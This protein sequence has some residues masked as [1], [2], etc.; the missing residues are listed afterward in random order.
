L[1]IGRWQAACEDP[2]VH[3]LDNP[4][5]HALTGPQQKVADLRS[6]AARYD[7]E[8]AAFAA[9]PDVPTPETWDD[10]RD[11]VGEGGVAVLFVKPPNL[12]DGWDE[13]FRIPTVQMVATSVTPAEAADAGLLGPDDVEDMLALVSRTHPGPFERRTIELGDYI[14]VRD[15]AGCLVAMAG[16]RMRAPGHT[17]ISAVC[18][19]EAARGRGLA[20][21][22]VRDLVGRILDRGEV[23]ILHVMTTNLSAIRV[24][25]QLGFTIRREQDVI[26]LRPPE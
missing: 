14:G 13:L 6:G 7:P 16:M 24:Y 5:W 15:E 20:S 3:V 23:P 22:L 19:D 8:V 4:V 25:D 1:L 12:P 18:T 26:G 9:V 10:L 17:E 2:L 11:L 21:A